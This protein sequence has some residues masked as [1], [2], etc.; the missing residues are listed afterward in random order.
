MQKKSLKNSD[1]LFEDRYIQ[2][3]APSE[4]KFASL[5]ETS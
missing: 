3:V 2:Y 4:A 1:V 5:R